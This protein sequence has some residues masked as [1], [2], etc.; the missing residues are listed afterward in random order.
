MS[1]WLTRALIACAVLVGVV[2]LLIPLVLIYYFIR[3]KGLI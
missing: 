3:A 1:R 2:L